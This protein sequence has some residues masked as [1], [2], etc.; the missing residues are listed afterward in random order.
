MEIQALNAVR[1]GFLLNIKK[2]AALAKILKATGY[3]VEVYRRRVEND[4]DTLKADCKNKT[5]SI[6]KLTESEGLD[7][8]KAITD[9]QTNF[10]KTA[11]C[12]EFVMK[13]IEKKLKPNNIGLYPKSVN[14]P[15]EVRPF[16]TAEQ[17]EVLRGM[18]SAQFK[19]IFT[20][21]EIN[22]AF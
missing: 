16:L 15:T 4:E 18:V 21:H 5:A 3:N 7:F 22:I 12:V 20:Q 13:S 9:I 2:E 14:L 17:R 10:C 1:L 11:R 6:A 19:P 8:Q